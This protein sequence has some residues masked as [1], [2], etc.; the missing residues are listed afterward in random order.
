MITKPVH[1]HID[2]YS[3]H[4]NALAKFALQQMMVRYPDMLPEELLVIA[5]CN[6]LYQDTTDPM[7]NLRQDMVED[8]MDYL[9]DA[10]GNDTVTVDLA[11]LKNLDL[12]N[13]WIKNLCPPN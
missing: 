1:D 4:L 13:S 2:I 9:K 12:L 5:M 3:L 8:C 10:Y 11:G 6:L 7:G